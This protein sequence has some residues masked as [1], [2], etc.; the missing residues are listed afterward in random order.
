M[1]ENQRHLFD[2]P[3]DVHYLNCAYMSPLLKSSVYAGHAAIDAKARPWCISPADFFVYTNTARDLFAR[4]INARAEDISIASSVSYGT[5]TAALNVPLNSGEKV[6][7]LAEE[8]PSNLYSWRVKAKDC[9]AE[10]KV[11]E[12]PEDT[13]WTAAVLNTLEDKAVTVVVIPQTHWIDGGQLDLEAIASARAERDFALVIDLTQSLGVV[14]V[15]VQIIQPDFLI[16][17]SY[18]WLLGP[19]SLGFVYVNPRHHSGIPLEQGWINRPGA[20]DFSRLI[21]YVDEINLDATRFDMGE[22]SN[23][24]L[25]PIA[26]AG[27]EQIHRWGLSEIETSLRDYTQALRHELEEIGFTACDESYRSPHYLAVQHADGLPEN[28][29]GQLAEEKIYLS[30]R[31]DS[32]RISPHLYNNETDALSLVSAL[33][34]ALRS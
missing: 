28:I 32:L 1:L 8:F 15:D 3:E 23:F 2:I 22:R 11:V 30:R 27:L 10:I 17:A 31:G 26:I 25:M 34:N 4:L 7:V 12:R 33:K 9:G 19:Y 21:D 13:N 29:L 6:L 14:G 5:A 18:K 24:H 16:C 20:E